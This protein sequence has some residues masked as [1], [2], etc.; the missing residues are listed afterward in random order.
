MTARA[1]NDTRRIETPT[2]QTESSLLQIHKQSDLQNAADG[3]EK[4]QTEVRTM[5]ETERT[6]RN[7]S[8]LLKE[9]GH[10]QDSERG[11][12]NHSD[13]LEELRDEIAQG[14]LYS[15]ARANHNTGKTLQVSSFCYALIELLSEKGVV[16]IE[17]LDERKKV[18]ADRL[19]KEFSEK[20]IGALY[21][22]Y[23]CDKYKFDKKVDI[24]CE[25]R[26]HLCKAA[27]CRIFGLALS[28]QDIKEGVVRWNLGHPYMI[29]K[30]EDGYCKHLSRPAYR[31]TVR[32]H[33]PVP[34]RAFDCRTDERIWLDFEKKT[35]NPRLSRLLENSDLRPSDCLELR[36]AKAGESNG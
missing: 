26:I 3:N 28:R 16:T 24:D 31:C 4:N 17:E 27:C 14:L 18:V 21:Q 7:R 6:A 25:N 33:R 22:D 35:I 23:E 11:H 2:V 20:G 9:K 12:G 8:C 34:C 10:L 32:E 29:A 19:I 36:M 13:F 30:G 15:H 1:S 5:S